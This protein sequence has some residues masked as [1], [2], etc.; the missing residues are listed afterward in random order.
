VDAA[1]LVG[2]VMTDVLDTNDL[3][4]RAT[5]AA[6]KW[7]P[8]CRIEHVTFL[9]GGTVS[10]V[11]TGR[12]ADA[13]GGVDTVVLK[14]APPGLEPRRNRDVLRQARCIDSLG[15]VPGVAVPPVLFTDLGRPVEVPPFFATPMLP[16]DCTEPLLVASTRPLPADIVRARA[17][18][19]VDVLVAMRKASPE[20]IGL[21]DEP[22]T[23]PA[24]EVRRWIRTFETVPDEYRTGY[25]PV[26][27]AL[28]ATAPE[29]SGPAVVHGDYRLGNMLCDGRTINGIIDWELW[30]I[31]DPRIDLSWLLFFTDDAGHPSGRHGVPSGMP[32]TAEL[33]GAYE[34]GIGEAV[35]DLTWFDALTYFK[36]ASATALIAKLARRRNPDAPDV[37]PPSFCTGLVERASSIVGSGR[38]A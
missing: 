10:V 9:P 37:I 11:Y 24:D 15:R 13:G 3:A 32:S 30:T 5:A 2:R 4:L 28:L 14:V 27:E 26:G 21:G 19:A 25:A 33:L 1:Q 35:A 22:V 12:V 18:A 16:G 17:F 8:G 20:S 31:S 7:T 6:Q 23:T 36:E 29:L 34:A 38:P